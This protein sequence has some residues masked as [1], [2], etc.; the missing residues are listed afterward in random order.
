MFRFFAILSIS[1]L[2]LAISIHSTKP[3]AESCSGHPSR[4]ATFYGRAQT[5]ASS[6][7]TIT[8][9]QNDQPVKVSDNTAFTTS[10]SNYSSHTPPDN[11][12]QHLQRS[13]NVSTTATAATTPNGITPS[14]TPQLMNPRDLQAGEIALPRD[15][16]KGLPRENEIQTYGTMG[17]ATPGS[18]GPTTSLATFGGSTAYPTGTGIPGSDNIAFPF[19]S[20]QYGS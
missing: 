2:I 10:E 11:L 6:P 4:I 5:F 12:A 8:P 18:G 17:S 13:L 16:S 19:P 7:F 15:G 3:S 20:C 14:G 1:T 9:K